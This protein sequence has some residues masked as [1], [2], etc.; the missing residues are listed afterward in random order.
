MIFEWLIR[1]VSTPWGTT[2]LTFGTYDAAAL[3]V[4]ITASIREI[5]HLG[6]AECRRCA[7][8]VNTILIGRRSTSRAQI[9]VRISG[10]RRTCQITGSKEERHSLRASLMAVGAGQPGSEDPTSRRLY[11]CIWPRTTVAAVADTPVKFGLKLVTI[12]VGADIGKL[13]PIPSCFTSQRRLGAPGLGMLSKP[14][15]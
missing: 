4:A 12:S 6:Y 8:E 3:V 2:A 11:L 15:A 14:K 10:L 1:F 9:A 5:S 7:A 13:C